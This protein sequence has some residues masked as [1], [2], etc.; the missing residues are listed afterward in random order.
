MLNKRV[1]N[2]INTRILMHMFQYKNAELYAENV[3]IK[4]LAEEFG[5]PLYIYSYAALLRHLRAYQEAF[6][7]FP[8]IVCFALKANSNSAILRLFAKNNGGADV[9]SGGELYRALKAGIT[10]SKIVYA[11]VGKT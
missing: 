10:A 11:G 9:V 8:H 6:D 7:G 4:R 1:K 5:T 3:P 2:Q